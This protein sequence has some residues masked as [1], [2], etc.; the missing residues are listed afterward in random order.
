MLYVQK[1]YQLFSDISTT[2][3]DLRAS[4]RNATNYSIQYF[5]FVFELENTVFLGRNYW[6]LLEMLLCQVRMVKTFHPF[7]IHV[8]G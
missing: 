3:I 5:F 1:C 8:D 7:Y 6:V 2:A 4:P